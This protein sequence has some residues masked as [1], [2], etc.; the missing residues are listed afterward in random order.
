MRMHAATWPQRVHVRRGLQEHGWRGVVAIKHERVH[1]RVY[2]SLQ[3]PWDS[4]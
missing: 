1:V 2:R 3:W 4:A